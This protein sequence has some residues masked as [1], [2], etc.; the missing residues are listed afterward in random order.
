MEEKRSGVTGD[1][2]NEGDSTSCDTELDRGGTVD[3][4]GARRQEFV[5]KFS[6]KGNIPPTPPR[7]AVVGS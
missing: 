2:V 4:V 6:S 5:K 7:E 3:E 1:C